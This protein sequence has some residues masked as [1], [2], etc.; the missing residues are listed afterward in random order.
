MRDSEVR[1][2][3]P[4]FSAIPSLP[5]THF[6]PTTTLLSCLPCPL[7]LMLSAAVSVVV[8]GRP[9]PSSSTRSSIRYSVLSLI[10]C[11]ITLTIYSLPSQISISRIRRQHRSWNDQIPI[12]R[13]RHSPI[14]IMRTLF[15]RPVVWVVV[16]SQ[17]WILL[18]TSEHSWRGVSTVGIGVKF[19][20]GGWSR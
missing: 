9:L 11:L 2:K 14:C 7:V 5:A 18:P 10:D 19:R 6:L 15:W 3:S 20:T 17:G 12:V 8:T 4:L 16:S 1:E 13:R